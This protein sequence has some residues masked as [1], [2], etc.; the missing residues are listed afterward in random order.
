MRT[1]NP[2]SLREYAS[3]VETDRIPWEESGTRS[4]ED[5]WKEFLILGLRQ[6]EGISVEEGERRYGPR[7]DGLPEAVDRLVG[8]GGLV[9]NRDRLRMP[10]RHWFVSNEVLRRL[11]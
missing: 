7:P 1:A 9:R 8:S 5:A 6:E 2:P 3:R 11:A 10:R 4:R